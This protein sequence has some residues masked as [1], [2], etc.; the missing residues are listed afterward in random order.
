MKIAATCKIALVVCLL[1]AC[2]KADVPASGR[3]ADTVGVDTSAN[4]VAKQAYEANEQAAKTVLAEFKLVLPAIDSLTRNEGWRLFV[5][6]EQ[7]RKLHVIRELASLK[8]PD[9]P[10]RLLSPVTFYKYQQ[11]HWEQ[12]NQGMGSDLLPINAQTALASDF[13]DKEKVYFYQMEA[14][15]LSKTYS[16]PQEFSETLRALLK[17]ME[18]DNTRLM[19]SGFI[20]GDAEP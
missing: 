14:V 1:N 17:K 11:G 13:T 10:F 2:S 19:K 16:N 5:D 18:A 6:N 12:D 9:G 15:D 20:A 7:P 8:L 3:S 4:T